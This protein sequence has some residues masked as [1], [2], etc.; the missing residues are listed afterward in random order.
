[1]KTMKVTVNKGNMVQL[2]LELATQMQMKEGDEITLVYDPQRLVDKCFIVEEDTENDLKNE[3]YCIPMRT[4]AEVG[5]ENEDLQLIL[6]TK[7][8]TLTS[9]GNV[10]S[11]IP[12]EVIAAMIDEKVDLTAITDHLVERINNHVLETEEE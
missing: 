10:L 3:Y 1:M 5:L 9:T 8:I 6:G 7:E 2:P 12:T 11:I 4:F